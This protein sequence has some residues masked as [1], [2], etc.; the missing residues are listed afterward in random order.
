MALLWRDQY[1][2][3]PGKNPVANVPDNDLARLMYYLH[4]V[5]CAIEYKDQDVRKYRDYR[6]YD[7][8]SYAEQRMV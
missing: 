3:T 5:F 1:D 6:N 4:C 7:E 2:L 8:L